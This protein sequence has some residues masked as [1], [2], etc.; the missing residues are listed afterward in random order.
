VF[1]L[2]FLDDMAGALRRAWSWLAPGGRLAITVW[3][4]VVLAP[5]EA[6][7]WDAVRREEPA[8][9]HISK[10]DLLARPGALEQ[11]FIEAGIAAPAVSLER[12]RMPLASPG[13][14][15]PVILGTSNR[16]VFDALSAGA[17]T[18]VK[19]E[20]LDRLRD[21]HVGDLDMEARVAIARKGTV[22]EAEIIRADHGHAV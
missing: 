17:Q 15:W 16:G 4:E 20:V 8:R 2:F 12:W 5:G 7:F 13:A 22:V 9:E 3:G 21:E 6:F 14:F 19:R 10:T 11:L 18:R 1:G